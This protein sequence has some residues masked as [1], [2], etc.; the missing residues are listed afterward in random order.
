MLGFLATPEVDGM[1]S[2]D[3]SWYG[4]KA[5]GFRGNDKTLLLLTTPAAHV[6][7]RGT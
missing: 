2:A 6:G 1:V 4:S 3:E 5:T 7:W